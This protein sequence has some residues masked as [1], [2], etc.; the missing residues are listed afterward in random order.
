MLIVISGLLFPKSNN[1]GIEINFT[2]SNI[3]AQITKTST[4]IDR[5]KN[6]TVTQTLTSFSLCQVFPSAQLNS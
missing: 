3:Q 5:G 6:K 2:I 4:Q 1:T